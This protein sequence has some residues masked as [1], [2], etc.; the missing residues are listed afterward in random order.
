MKTIY[1][2]L[3]L[4]ESWKFS[5]LSRLIH[6]YGVPRYIIFIYVHLNL[7]SIVMRSRKWNPFDL[8]VYEDS[9]QLQERKKKYTKVLKDYAKTMRTF[10]SNGVVCVFSILKTP[11][12]IFTTKQK[13]QYNRVNLKEVENMW[14]FQRTDILDFT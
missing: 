1:Y 5:Y 10:L 9:D 4:I 11:K 7:Y 2:G 12:L 3:R 6:V 8:Q 14:Y 13:L